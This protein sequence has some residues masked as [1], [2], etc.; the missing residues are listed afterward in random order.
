M[1]ENAPILGIDI[2][3]TK[4]AVCLALSNGKVLAS[5]RI[6]NRMRTFRSGKKTSRE[7]RQSRRRTERCSSSRFFLFCLFHFP[8]SALY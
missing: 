3:G 1:E 4:I 5:S 2:D 8:K 7:F 6:D